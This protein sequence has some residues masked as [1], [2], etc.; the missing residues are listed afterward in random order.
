MSWGG[1]VDEGF[2]G[3]VGYGCYGE[4]SVLGISRSSKASNFKDRAIRRGRKRV[5]A[6]RNCP[7]NSLTRDRMAEVRSPTRSSLS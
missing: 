5:P 3:G 6:L 4:K 2:M 7:A 1:V